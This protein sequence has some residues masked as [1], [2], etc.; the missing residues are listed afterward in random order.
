MKKELRVVPDTTIFGFLLN[1][2]NISEILIKIKEDKYFKVVGLNIVRQEIKKVKKWKLKETKSK[3]LNIYESM[4]DTEKNINSKVNS[5]AKK[6][7]SKYLD[8]GGKKDFEDLKTDLEIVAYASIHN[9]DIIISG[10]RETHNTTHPKGAIFQT[11]Y[12]EV[13]AT[14][15]NFRTPNFWKYYLLKQRYGFFN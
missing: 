13:N 10:D 12:S 3:I 5:L 4:I 1:E 2:K 7:Y 9:I 6:Y 8:L 15:T 11:A 14:D